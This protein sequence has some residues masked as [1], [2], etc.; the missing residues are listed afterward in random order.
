MYDQGKVILHD[1]DVALRALESSSA[2]IVKETFYFAN[3]KDEDQWYQH[4]LK[5]SERSCPR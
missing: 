3:R 2:D 1:V 4:T 5:R